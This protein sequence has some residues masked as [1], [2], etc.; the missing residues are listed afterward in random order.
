MF[1]INLL[2]FVIKTNANIEQKML[3]ANFFDKNLMF[4]DKKTL[5]TQK[6]AMQTKLH[7][8]IIIFKV[9][10]AETCYF[11]TFATDNYT[12]DSTSPDL[13]LRSTS[14]PSTGLI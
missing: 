10:R 4:F 13:T 14:R 3:S 7:S 8:L 2:S 11:G 9:S 1:L 12:T 6:K 5:T